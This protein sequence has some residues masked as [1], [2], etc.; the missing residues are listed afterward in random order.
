MGLPMN[1]IVESFLTSMKNVR[2]WLETMLS[3]YHTLNRLLKMFHFGEKYVYSF[4][5]G[6]ILLFYRLFPMVKDIDFYLSLYQYIWPHGFRMLFYYIIV[7]VRFCASYSR[8]YTI[9]Y[10]VLVL[11]QYYT[12]EPTERHK[13]AFCWQCEIREVFIDSHIHVAMHFEY[14]RSTRKYIIVCI[15]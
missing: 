11:V 12:P 5:R 9:S 8:L 3:I 2:E 6:L 14:I 10:S 13:K 15:V 1:K 4:I 7:M